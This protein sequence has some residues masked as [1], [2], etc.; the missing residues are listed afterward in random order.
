MSPILRQLFVAASPQLAA[1]STGGLIGYPSVLLQQF[2]RNE[3]SIHADVNI[4]S[5]IA[6]VHGLAGAPSLFIPYMMQ[7]RGRK[8]GFQTCCLLVTLGWTIIYFSRNAATIIIGESFQG[9]GAKS[10]LVVSYMTISEMVHPKYRSILML[11]YNINQ[12]V[13]VTLVHS[14]GRFFHWKTISLIMA[15]PAI[16]AF[17]MSCSWPESPAWLAYK[18]RLDECKKSFI[19]LRGL[20]EESV[21]EMNTLLNSHTEMNDKMVKSR[22]KSLKD[23]WNQITSKD[24]YLPSFHML[25]L[26]SVYYCSGNLVFLVYAMNMIENVTKD[27]NAAFIGMIIMD[28]VTLLGNSI[29]Y[30][31][32]NY[33][34][35]KPVLLTSGIG[36]AIF[37]LASSIVSYLQFSNTL[38][39][40]SLLCLYFL[41]GFMIASSLG[42]YTTP[43]VMA[44]E[45]MPVRHRGAG[46]AL[47]VI[48]ICA[49]YSFTLKIAPYLVLYLKLHGTFLLYAVTLSLCLFWVWRFVPETKNKTLQCIEESYADKPILELKPQLDEV[50]EVENLNV[51]LV[52]IAKPKESDEIVHTVIPNDVVQSLLENKDCTDEV[53]TI[54][55]CN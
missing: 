23:F 26:L 3:S 8:F 30:V 32:F 40:D 11:F 18:G 34:N 52:L 25:V 15:L 45:I 51:R 21:S 14:M 37:L 35:N 10:L 7:L 44:A 29:A 49:S 47:M 24:F 22:K 9:L 5:W 19:W 16:I 36:S 12:S 2:K 13:G 46:G 53:T 27:E 39:S 54:E 17:L 55:R 31:F 20:N 50:N 41:V 6:S 43:Y 48:I 38:S 1:I 28:C 33:F 42:I 4:A